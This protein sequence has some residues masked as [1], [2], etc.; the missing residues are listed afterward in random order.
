M[1]KSCNWWTNQVSPLTPRKAPRRNESH[2]GVCRKTHLGT[3]CLIWSIA[4][5]LQ[6][7]CTSRASWKVWKICC[8]ESEDV[9]SEVHDSIILVE[10]ALWRRIGSLYICCGALSPCGPELFPNRNDG[11]SPKASRRQAMDLAQLR[12]AS[13]HHNL[14]SEARLKEKHMENLVLFNFGSRK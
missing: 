8:Q 13:R 12:G 11:W 6:K 2:T 7:K 4:T 5:G 9:G 3:N 14:A 1:S 10:V